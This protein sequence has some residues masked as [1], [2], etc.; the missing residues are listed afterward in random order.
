MRKGAALESGHV[1][2][3]DA[4]RLFIMQEA[5]ATLHS[6]DQF[7]PLPDDSLAES[8]GEHLHVPTRRHRWTL[9]D[10]LRLASMTCS[11]ARIL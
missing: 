3:I 8:P 1:F 7:R 5:A 6:K 10:N 9:G 11:W 4:T 2:A